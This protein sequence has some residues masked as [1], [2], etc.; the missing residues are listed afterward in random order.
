MSRIRQVPPTRKLHAAL[1]MAGFLAAML[2]AAAFTLATAM[3]ASADVCVSSYLTNEVLRYD[4]VTG[5]PV[6]ASRQRG[7]FAQPH[8]V[9]VGPDGNVYVSSGGTKSVLRYDRLMG[10]FIDVFVA[11]GSG[12]LIEP[13]GLTFGPD[14]N[15]YVVNWA[16]N[17]LRY[18][19]AT[20]AP[21]GT[22]ASPVLGGAFELVFGPDGNLFVTSFSFVHQFD[23]A[24][25]A[26]INLTF[27]GTPGGLTGLESR[28]DGNLYVGVNLGGAFDSLARFDGG[29]A[30]TS[31]PSV[32]P[33]LRAPSVLRLVLMRDCTLPVET[34][35]ALCVF[36]AQSGTFIDTFIT[37][38]SGGLD[39]PWDVVFMPPDKAPTVSGHGRFNTDGNGQVMFTLSNGKQASFDRVRGKRFSFAGQV[40]SVTGSGNDATLTGSGTWNGQSGYSLEVSVVDKGGWGRLEDTIAVV[41]RDPYGAV[42]FTSLGPQVLKQGDIAV[43]SADSG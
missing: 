25:G 16:F 33:R 40:E 35:I 18:D 6:G 29:Q 19:G 8:G 39:L 12:G 24:T 7:E 43:I 34:Q 37:T 32:T 20:G 14:G 30:R 4:E 2:L 31:A 11:P 28:P 15:L 3:P 5:A 10:A 27:A 41:I 13:Q 26:L 9:A 21:L 23:G 22:F 17:V 42:S 1:R 36:D 38:G